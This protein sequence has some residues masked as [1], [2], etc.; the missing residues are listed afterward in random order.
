M[1]DPKNIKGVLMRQENAYFSQP[2]IFYGSNENEEEEE[3][4]EN[5]E[6]ATNDLWFTT[7]NVNDAKWMQSSVG[8]QIQWN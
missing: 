4:E 2:F 5:Q 3:L 6:F 1:E 8:L 7:V